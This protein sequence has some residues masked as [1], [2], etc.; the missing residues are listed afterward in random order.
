MSFI[1]GITKTYRCDLELFQQLGLKTFEANDNKEVFVGVYN[2]P[3]HGDAKIS[4][5]VRCYP[6][7]TWKFDIE[8]ESGRKYRINTG[9]GPLSEYW[10]SVMKVATDCF[11]VVKTN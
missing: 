1:T 7:Q 4:L 5:S 8:T 6:A 2:I 10:P 9:S 11:N 3:N